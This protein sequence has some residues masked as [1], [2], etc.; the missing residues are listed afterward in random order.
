MYYS[1]PVILKDSYFV[2]IPIFFRSIYFSGRRYILEQ[3][4][5]ES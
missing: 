1:E 4:I 5:F 3:L 2:K